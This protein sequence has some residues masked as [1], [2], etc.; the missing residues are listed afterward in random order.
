[1]YVDDAFIVQDENETIIIKYRQAQDTDRDKEGGT[2]TGTGRQTGTGMGQKHRDRD[3]NRDRDRDMD[4]NSG[5][6]KDVDCVSTWLIVGHTPWD[7]IDSEFST[8]IWCILD[9]SML[10]LHVNSDKS[11]I[12]L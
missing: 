10:H 6:G 12:A 4:S 9:E 2:G 7:T 5:T 1:M 11:V 8:S 3:R